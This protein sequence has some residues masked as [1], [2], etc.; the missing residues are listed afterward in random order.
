MSLAKPLDA[1]AKNG[2]GA[3]EDEVEEGNKGP[4]NH[5]C[6]PKV[7]EKDQI[8]HKLTGGGWAGLG[9]VRKGHEIC[10]EVCEPILLSD[11]LSLTQE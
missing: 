8:E 7:M 4:S 11:P 5:K 3:G 2:D 10:V 9:A 6:T 1:Y